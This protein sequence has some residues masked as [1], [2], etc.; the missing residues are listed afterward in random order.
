MLLEY[1]ALMPATARRHCSGRVDGSPGPDAPGRGIVGE[2]GEFA[3][4]P[5]AR[6]FWLSVA[7]GRNENIPNPRESTLYEQ[8]RH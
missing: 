3:G 7:K 5:R 8:P 6:P 1:G 2:R 4:R